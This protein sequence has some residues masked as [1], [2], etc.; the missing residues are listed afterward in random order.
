ML[1][2]EPLP[3]PQCP[4]LLK[5][6]PK[7]LLSNL[8]GF[9]PAAVEPSR[10]SAHSQGPPLQSARSWCAPSSVLSRGRAHLAPPPPP[11]ASSLEPLL[12]AWAPCPL[13]V[14]TRGPGA[15][16]ETLPS[17]SAQGK[18]RAHAISPLQPGCWVGRSPVDFSLPDKVS[19]GWPFAVH[20]CP[21]FPPGCP[22]KPQ[23]LPQ[24]SPRV[25]LAA[26]LRPRPLA[27]PSPNCCHAH[28]MLHFDA[29]LL[30]SWGLSRAVS[31]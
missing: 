19:S 30:Q 26:A 15:P 13:G 22:G 9:F 2:S 28:R 4:L 31:M 14:A 12:R 23:P 21:H 1:G 18:A 7:E 8:G 29:S 25:L 20:A 16:T 6:R 3:C 10:V 17:E 5:R 11:T 24:V 27:A